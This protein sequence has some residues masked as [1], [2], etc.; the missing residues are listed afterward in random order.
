VS[1][2]SLDFITPS[3]ASARHL[4]HVLSF[5]G[6]YRQVLVGVVGCAAQNPDTCASPLHA[7]RRI[8]ASRI[9]RLEREVR[10]AQRLQPEVIQAVLKVRISRSSASIVFVGRGGGAV[11]DPTGRAD[12]AAPSPWRMTTLSNQWVGSPVAAVVMSYLGSL[13]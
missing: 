4:R 1:L 12:M 6:G 7:P 2:V 3:I 8:P 9:A 5:M 11:G 13:W 10:M